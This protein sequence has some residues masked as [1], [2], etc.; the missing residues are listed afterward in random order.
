MQTPSTS[1]PVVI[2]G[3]GHNGLV[4]AAALARQGLPVIVLEAS[5]AIG[6][7]CRTERPFEKAPGLGCSTGAYL[8]GPMPP[9]VIERTGIRLDIRPRKPSGFFLNDRGEPV[10]FGLGEAGLGNLSGHDRAALRAF[11]ETVAAIRDDLAPLWLRDAVTLE[12]SVQAVRD[13]PAGLPAADAPPGTLASSPCMLPDLEGSASPFAVA[14]APRTFRDLYRIL[15]FGPFTEFLDAFGFEDRSLA[16]T[17]AT[18]AL[19]GS[20]LG[21]SD[22]GVGMNFLAHNM[23]R[24]PEGGT[25]L[26]RAPTTPLG[27]WQLVT[28]GM[29]AV[30]AALAEAVR[31]AGGQ[32]RLNAPAAEILPT[33]GGRVR[34]RL[35][36]GGVL[37][38]SAV[39]LACDPASAG[40]LLPAEAPFHAKFR[41]FSPEASM[42]TSLKVN[43]ALRDLPRVVGAEAVGRT[44]LSGTVHA[45][46]HPTD[47]R[48]PIEGM[49]RAR[50]AALAGRLPDP[51]DCMIDVYTHTA[52]EPSLRDEQG[53]HAMSFF[54]QWVPAETTQEQAERFA[55]ELIAGPVARLLPDLPGLVEDMLVVA[56]RGIEQRFGIRGGHIH[57][58]DNSIAFD[59]RLGVR[60]AGLPGVLLA[61]AGCHPAGSVIGAAGLIAADAVLADL[62]R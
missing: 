32:I 13:D 20:P 52:V 24:L 29:G 25:G 1:L 18:D 62:A 35:A 3:A 27:A 23:L 16:A 33:D 28:G 36:D 53:R 15:A 21:L 7:A 22:T 59:R 48:D 30:T 51:F 19:V 56:P 31:E 47:G 61:G 60:D 38:A 10:W 17:L 14:A 40:R 45:L 49:E 26:G 2:V 5:G 43:L 9:E 57:H 58:L 50:R 34:L 6:G 12:E 54:V 44:P 11:D 4:C 41:G 37:E 39:V 8:L 42:G 46:P 55:R